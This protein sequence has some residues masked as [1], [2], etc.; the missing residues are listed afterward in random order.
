MNQFI[1][2]MLQL[3]DSN[4]EFDGQYVEEKNYKGVKSLFCRAKLAYTPLR[5]PECGVK[6]QD[7]T[8]VKNGTRISRIT[9]MHISGLPAYLLLKK[10]RFFCKACQSSFTAETS[11]VDQDCFISNR[12]K[13]HI[14]DQATTI[15][16]VKMIA[17]EHSVSWHTVQRV[18]TQAAEKLTIRPLSSLPDHLSW[19]EF[20]SVKS[21]DFSMSFVYCD[22]VTH[23][24]VDIVASRKKGE[25]TRYFQRFPL[26]VRKQVKTV[27]IDMY[28][29]YIQ[30]IPSLFP[31]AEII[32]DKFHI[33]QA[34]NRELNKDRI[35]IMNTY[36]YKDQ[37]LYN[38]F[39]KYWKLPLKDESTLISSTYKKFPLFDYLTNTQGIVDYLLSFNEQLRESYSVV[40]NLRYALST[41]RWGYF[42]S[43]FDQAKIKPLSKG[44]RRVLRT[45]RKHQKPVFN[46]LQFPRLT[47]GPIEGIN[48]KI[49]VL[50]RTAFG[51]KSYPNF[52][53]RILLMT[54]LYT[55]ETE[56]Q[57]R[58]IA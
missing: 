38:K 8:I 53:N 32:F 22:A 21:V 2:N 10:Q 34:L 44:L 43:T 27:T 30:L 1:A 17:N 58:R 6:N 26:S 45:L 23:R 5:C 33:V 35:N 20:K 49:K 19:D 11:I 28:E 54:R 7:Y 50:K 55:S 47:N 52:R 31:N 29:P 4:V 24:I 3:K 25:L 12:T 46:A 16:A 13:Q 37:R 40:Q 48:N 42:E 14:A 51:Y 41:Q 57:T 56:K 15:K 39:K 18:I 9:L 36:R